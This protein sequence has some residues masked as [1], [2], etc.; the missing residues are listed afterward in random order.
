MHRNLA[1]NGLVIFDF[2]HRAIRD[3][4]PSVSQMTPRMN[5]SAEVKRFGIPVPDR[6]TGFVSSWMKIFLHEIKI[7]NDRYLHF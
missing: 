1:D 4:N 2:R 7:V 3:N 6:P 5:S